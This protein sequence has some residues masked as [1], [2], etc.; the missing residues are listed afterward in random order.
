[1]GTIRKFF[2]GSVMMLALGGSMQAQEFGSIPDAR[3]LL[4]RAVAEV[5]TN[6]LRAFDRFNANDRKF[7]DRDLFVFCFGAENGSFV[8]H[9]AMVT[10]DVRT[11]RD[12]VGR[13]YGKE[14]FIN[15]REGDISEISYSSPFPGTTLE[16][17]KRALVT[18]VENYVCGVSAYLYNIAERVE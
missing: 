15:A 2:L 7:R 17:P 11:L 5:R 4:D 13:P 16:I 6:A 8:A 18:R 12:R 9:E 3:A 14:M 1:M 10:H